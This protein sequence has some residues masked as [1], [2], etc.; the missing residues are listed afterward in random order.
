M[1]IDKLDIIEEVHQIKIKNNDEIA[2]TILKKAETSEYDII[3]LCSMINL[4][5]AQ[6][7]A[8]DEVEIL[9]IVTEIE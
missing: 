6:N 2:Q 7:K 3:Q 5:I 4:W 8:A 1:K 9:E